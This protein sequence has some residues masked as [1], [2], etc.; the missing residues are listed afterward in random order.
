MKDKEIQDNII[1]LK[2]AK[3]YEESRRIQAELS[4]HY[5]YQY[6]KD[7]VQHGRNRAVLINW[8]LISIV[9]LLS[10]ILWRVW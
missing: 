4:E 6:L 10:L 5:Q 2:Q 7:Q 3:N 1:K 8:M 9:V